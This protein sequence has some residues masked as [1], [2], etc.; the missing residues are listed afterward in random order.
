VITAGPRAG[1]EPDLGAG[2][3]PGGADALIAG[4]R[5]H[6]RRRWQRRAVLAVIF[7]LLA[8]ALGA[9]LAGLPGRAGRP[10]AA[11]APGP[12]GYRQP[13]PP[14][15]VVLTGSSRIEVLSARTGRVLRTLAADAGLFRR[16]PTVAVSVT[17]MV[18]FDTVLTQEQVV[19]VPV[20]GGPVRSVAAGSDPAVSPDGRM[21]A[22]VTGAEP[23]RGPEAI[24]VRNL[25]TGSQRRW[26]FISGQA[27]IVSLSWSPDGVLLSFT[28]DIGSTFQA[29]AWLLDTRRAGTLDS[30]RP[31]PLGRG[32]RWAG[33]LTPRAGMAVTGPAG[34]P[35]RGGQSLAEVAVSSGR[36]LRQLTELPRQGLSTSNAYD[37]AEGTITA[38]PGGHYLL[39][40]T[41]GPDGYG[42]IFRWT[43]GTH[44]LVP[45]ARGAIRASWAG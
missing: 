9:G 6:R 10:A 12:P 14:L 4:A 11:T 17:G 35:G 20:A 18:Y 23:H 42:E 30:A 36:I 28:A 37:G 27:D 21:L 34:P 16:L 25:A 40:A 45:L 3:P 31:I 44:Q 22:Y 19:S 5:R 1:H 33:F 29:T 8:A 41:A 38:H 32:L 39:I 13:M 26:A 24:V 15:V 7:I 2:G 43:V